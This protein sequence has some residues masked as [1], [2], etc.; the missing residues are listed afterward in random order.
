MCL[1]HH[2]LVLDGYPRSANSYMFNFAARF[3][4]GHRI[5][6]HSHASAT[7]KMARRFGVPTF[8]LVRDPMDAVTSN[9]IRSGGNLPYHEAHYAQY[10]R[11]VDDHREAFTVV[12]FQTAIEDP[13]RV[14][15]EI[16]TSLGQ[17]PSR[18]S[19]EAVAE[20]EAAIS[21][22]LERLAEDKYGD[23]A[24]A[25][26][27]VPDE[28]REQQKARVRETVRERGPVAE[29]DALYEALVGD[30]PLARQAPA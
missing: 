9:V 19:P 25:K 4:D 5:V 30:A 12:P 27:A 26:K 29:L 11:Y 24:D 3:L 2:D 16:E 1:P 15:A 18:P 6:H 17:E 23:K 10:H 20:A 14:L 28:D 7:L 22:H 13:T 8:V 21:A